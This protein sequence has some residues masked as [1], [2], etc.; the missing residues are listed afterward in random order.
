MTEDEY[1]ADQQKILT[2]AIEAIH[3]AR[4][5]YAGF[6]PGKQQ[7]NIWVSKEDAG[8]FAHAALNGIKAA[9][10]KIVRR[11]DSEPPESPLRNSK[12]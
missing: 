3:R 11:D 4:I 8:L 1:L 7:D 9:G 2:A 12:G 6:D 10:F 5:D